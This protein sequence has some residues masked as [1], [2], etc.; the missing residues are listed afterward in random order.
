V[1]E[2]K[3]TVAVVIENYNG[4]DAAAATTREFLAGDPIWRVV[5]AAADD[6]VNDAL[7]KWDQGK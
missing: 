3:V 1:S 5:Q 6:A 4:K 7:D 2:P